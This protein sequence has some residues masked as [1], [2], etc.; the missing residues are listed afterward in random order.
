MILSTPL[1]LT[2]PVVNGYFEY[3]RNRNHSWQVWNPPN[4]AS[5]NQKLKTS[6][7][8]FANMMEFE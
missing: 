7:V 8:S 4:P 3:L 1:F 6:E 2:T 5:R